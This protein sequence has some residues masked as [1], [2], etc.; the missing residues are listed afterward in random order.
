VGENVSGTPGNNVA[1]AIRFLLEKSGCPFLL[2][3]NRVIKNS[4][5]IELMSTAKHRGAHT[6]IKPFELCVLSGFLNK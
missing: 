3:K 2:F 4:T 1:R 6:S 5:A